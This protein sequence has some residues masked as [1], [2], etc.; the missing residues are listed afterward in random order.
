[1][2]KKLWNN[3][4]SS[5]NI[6]EFPTITSSFFLMSLGGLFIKK[7]NISLS[8]FENFSCPII[9]KQERKKPVIL[10]DF[11]N[12][13]SYNK[14]SLKRFDF[15]EKER[16]FT[17]L[18]LFN[19]AH[20]YEIITVSDVDKYYGHNILNKIDPYGFI[21]YRIFLD[22]VKEL[23]K[24]KL[25]R[26][27]NH[28]AIISTYTFQFNNDFE[29]NVINIKRWRGLKEDGL[30]DLMHFFINLN[31]MNLDDLRPTLKSYK[32]TDFFKS[33]KKNQR[34]LYNQRNLFSFSRFEEKL[35]EVNNNKIIEYEKIKNK[36]S[37]QNN[38]ENKYKDLIIRFIKNMI[39]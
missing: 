39:F 34:K 36:F 9:P 2:F 10:F 3:F 32:N 19:I 29:N 12:F 6:K 35:K 11:N 18:F 37:L 28:L 17:Q 1:M 21:T 20:Y 23:N 14:F 16:N 7:R 22:D 8:L 5:E 15:I 26:S 31:N 27:L 25:N 4:K 33:F 30:F 24:N 38:K 13:L